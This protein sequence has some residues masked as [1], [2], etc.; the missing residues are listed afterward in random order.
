MKGGEPPCFNL[1]ADQVVTAYL[2]LGTNIG[3]RG[4]NLGEALRRLA[5]IAGVETVSSIYETEPVGYREQPEF[6]NVVVRVRTDLPAAQLMRAL[7]TIERDMGRER[8]FRNAPRLIDIDILLY[9]DVITT[10]DDLQ[11]PHPRMHERA[12]VLKPLLEIAPDITDPR[13]GTRY[14]DF[15]ASTQ[16]ARAERIGHVDYETR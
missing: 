11:L 3:D 7:I 5:E 2:G 13:T 16:L 12:F 8:T 14:A 4:R 9:D 10:T 1:P 6:W 15:L